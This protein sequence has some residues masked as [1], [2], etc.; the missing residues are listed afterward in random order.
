MAQIVNNRS[1]LTTDPIR[2]FRFLVTFK[3]HSD[4]LKNAV[5]FQATMGFTSVSGLALTTDSIPY[6]EGGYNTTVHQLPGQT[7]FSP[8]T[9]QRG[10]MLG[11]KQ[12]WDWMRQLFRTVSGTG[13]NNATTQSTD[14]R[15][16]IEIAVLSHPISGGA[17]DLQGGFSPNVT[18]LQNSAATAYDDH[19]AMRFQV[20]NAWPT[21]IAYSDLNA[22][23]NALLVE[24]MTLVHEGFDLNWA[25]NLTTTAADFD[26]YGSN[27]N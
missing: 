17:T 24:Q 14:F 26:A 23:D 1:N 25:E 4:G 11:S 21:S 16:D 22:G 2:N 7:Q 27:K 5:E 3:P 19:V 12:H 13:A 6:R 15:C 18:G 8:I 10:V 9:L 20:Y